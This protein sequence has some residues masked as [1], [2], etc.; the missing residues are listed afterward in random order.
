VQGICNFSVHNTFSLSSHH[1]VPTFHSFTLLFL[2]LRCFTHSAMSALEFIRSWSF[3]LVFF[4]SV[5]G[6]AFCQTGYTYVLDTEYSGANFFNG[7]EFFTVRALQTVVYTW[8]LTILRI[9]W[10]SDEWVCPVS[11]VHGPSC[12]CSDCVPDTSINRRL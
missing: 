11:H 1:A 8:K 2:V 3:P 4:L 9:V 10:R 6:S 5:S 7:W 12:S